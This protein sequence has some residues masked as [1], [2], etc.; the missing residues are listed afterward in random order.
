VT[1]QLRQG[2]SKPLPPNIIPGH[3]A[4]WG[5]LSREDRLGRVI[6]PKGKPGEL[7]LYFPS[8]PRSRPLYVDFLW[9]IHR[10]RNTDTISTRFDTVDGI[11]PVPRGSTGANH[12]LCDPKTQRRS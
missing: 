3:S 7:D 9:R 2:D 4:T 8:G 10:G 12:G 1:C 5:R 6:I 11:L